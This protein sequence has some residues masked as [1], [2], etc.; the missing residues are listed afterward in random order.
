MC[1]LVMSLFSRRHILF[2][3]VIYTMSNSGN[4]LEARIQNLMTPPP[5]VRT[6]RQKALYRA[7]AN[8]RIAELRAL[9]RRARQRRA[10]PKPPSPSRRTTGRVQSRTARTPSVPTP[11]STS[12]SGSNNLRRLIWSRNVVAPHDIDRLIQLYVMTHRRHVN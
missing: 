5:S 10:V 2:F 3:F 12:R 11:T 4:N 7:W 1:L 9:Q 6:R 8:R